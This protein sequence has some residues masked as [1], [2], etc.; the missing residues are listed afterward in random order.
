[1]IDE[2]DYRLFASE[3]PVQVYFFGKGVLSVTLHSL[4]C[5]SVCPVFSLENL[6]LRQPEF[7]YALLHI[8][9][10]KEVVLPADG[11]DESFLNHIAVLILV[12][13]NV[14]EFF[15]EKACGL[16][17]LEDFVGAVLDV[18]EV[19]QTFFSLKPVVKAAEFLD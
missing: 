10:H 19:H 9:D 15:S 11:A 1:M 17:V 16:I 14:F 8:A 13:E 4:H 18:V 12:Y 5:L 7:I 3:I 6:R 2:V